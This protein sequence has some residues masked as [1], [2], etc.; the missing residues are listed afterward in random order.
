M[1]KNAF[2]RLMAV[3]LLLGLSG[4]NA[5]PQLVDRLF[6]R[7]DRDKDE[8][9]SETELLRATRLVTGNF[10]ETTSAV[11][12]WFDSDGNGVIDFGEWE[13]GCRGDTTPPDLTGAEAIELDANRNGK[14]SR[15]EFWRVI[16]KFVP[17]PVTRK[18]FAAQFPDSQVTGSTGS[19]S[20]S[21]VWGGGVSGATLT[22]GDPSSWT[23]LSL[24]NLGLSVG[25]V[26]LAEG[27]L[28]QGGTSTLDTQS[29]SSGGELTGS[30]DSNADA[31]VLTGVPGGLPA[32][33][34][35]PDLGHGS[36]PVDGVNGTSLG[37]SGQISGTTTVS[38]G[39][40]QPG[41]GGSPLTSAD[42]VIVDTLP[43]NPASGFTLCV[44]PTAGDAVGSG[45]TFSCWDYGK[46]FTFEATGTP[47]NGSGWISGSTE[48]VFLSNSQIT[49]LGLGN[50][51]LDTLEAPPL[52]LPLP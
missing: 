12:G 27:N 40:L 2:M 37:G 28:P 29:T 38:G 6:N 36:L 26:A 25:T 7:L 39:V 13:D 49:V 1:Q 8:L 42:W 32:V 11:H 3:F 43:L 47:M 31:T 41:S 44:G 20:G 35:F 48:D 24:G 4:A 19:G 30:V 21:T 15:A 5:A 22:V 50:S 46:S 17:G 33:G 9:L 34:S 16:P 51:T 18:W 10:K 23:D 14:V 52:A 45:S